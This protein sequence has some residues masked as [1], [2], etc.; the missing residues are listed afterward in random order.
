MHSPEAQP[1]GPYA[2]PKA[3]V[4]SG[5]VST[6]RHPWVA[7]LFAVLSPMYAMLYV[8][9][10]WRALG[11]IAAFLGLFA[12]SFAAA[13][14]SGIRVEAFQGLSAIALRVIGAIDGY[15]CANAWPES[16]RLPWYA[17]WPGLVSIAVVLIL[18][19]TALRA[20]VVEPFR[21]PSGAMIPT[22]FVG[23][24]ILVSKSAYGLR[25]PLSERPFVMLSQPKHG[26]VAVFLYPE[27][28]KIHYIKRVVGVPGDRIA[29][30]DKQLSIN[31]QPM[32]M[33]RVSDHAAQDGLNHGPLQ[34]YME[35]LRGHRH[36]LLINP[37][38]PPVQLATV[39]QF[40]HRDACEYS[41][42]G[43]VC[44][45]PR[46]HY[47]MMGDNRDASSDSRYWGFV[48]E[49]N[50]VGRALIVWASTAGAERVGKKIR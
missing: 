17:R 45:V 29:Y 27:N 34:E 33:T 43:F 47:F 8:A 36:N 49:A 24:Y 10:G 32:T 9:R 18:G 6:V 31:D 21:I 7:V 40:P 30:L 20:F 14:F 4:D 48:P 3:Q 19:L 22:L 44:T 38:M 28:P 23:D 50:L 16:A 46:G 13:A 5:G 11:Y 35:D 37:G 26:D 2:P 39:R 12:L 41:E 15:R 25:L 42:R 1:D